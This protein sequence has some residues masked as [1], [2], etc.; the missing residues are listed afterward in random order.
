MNSFLDCFGKLKFIDF[1]GFEWFFWSL[2]NFC[3]FCLV[4]CQQRAYASGLRS[5]EFES[6]LASSL[7]CNRCSE[8]IPFD[9]VLAQLF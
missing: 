3:S 4:R 7:R 2:A 8:G 6:I 1:K 5:D 9:L